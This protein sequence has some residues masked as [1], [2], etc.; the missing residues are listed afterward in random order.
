MKRHTRHFCGKQSIY[1]W[2]NKLVPLEVWVGRGGRREET[3]GGASWGEDKRKGRKEVCPG[4][5]RHLQCKQINCDKTLF[6]QSQELLCHK[7]RWASHLAF[8]SLSFPTCPLEKIISPP[9]AIVR[10]K[11]RGLSEAPPGHQH[12]VGA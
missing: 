7:T 12:I 4:L 2:R 3:D 6:P 1:T 9:Q 5:G 8:L 10:V 11:W